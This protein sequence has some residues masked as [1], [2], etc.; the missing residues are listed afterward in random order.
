MSIEVIH[1]IILHPFIKESIHSLSA[2]TH[3]DSKAGDIFEDSVDD[4]RFKGYA[5]CSEIQGELDGVIL[6]HHYEETA[7]A[8]GASVYEGFA[9]AAASNIESLNQDLSDALAEW[10][11][12]IVGRATDLLAKHNLGFSFSAPQ[13]VV[14]LDDMS[15]YLKGV[16]TIVTVPI[17][18]E[19]V[20]RYFF[21]L[22]IR[23]TATDHSIEKMVDAKDTVETTITP[24]AAPL[25]NDA[26]ILLV[27]DSPLIRKA[28]S[29]YLDK[30]G[31]NNILEASDGDEAVDIVAA[32]NPDFLFMD[33]VMGKMNGD[34]ALEKIRMSN[35]DVAIVMLSSVTDSSV[36]SNCQNL[37][38]QGFV[39]KPL[40]SDT[41]PAILSR[42]LG[43]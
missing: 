43:L 17:H 25:P 10:G 13:T 15:Q 14:N 11:N 37:G 20:G 7:L 33:I 29:R 32:Q 36:I 34:I 27:D 18:V 9:G 28:L 38:I 31:Y 3:M 41:A 8:I 42:C 22:L 19:G 6:M 16:E 24:L 26:K 21:N 40:N 5:V 4:F 23:K 39:I 2:M 35:K 1:K 30:L 12:T